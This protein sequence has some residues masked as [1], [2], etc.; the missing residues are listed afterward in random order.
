MVLEEG[1]EESELDEAEEVGEVA[2]AVELWS[3]LEGGGGNSGT[4][5]RSSSAGGSLRLMALSSPHHLAASLG[6][7][8]TS[9]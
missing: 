3:A 6:L 1:E 8:L 9:L 2:M 5:R 4:R 7:W